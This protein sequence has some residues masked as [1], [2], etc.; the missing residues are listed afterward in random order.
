MKSAI[1]G[2]FFGYSSFTCSSIQGIQGMSGFL[3]T[4]SEIVNFSFDSLKVYNL[5]SKLS[6]KP[7]KTLAAKF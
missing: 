2:A 1:F 6:G 4:S 5:R 3:L 7:E